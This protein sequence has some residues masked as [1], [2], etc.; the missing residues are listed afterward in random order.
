MF[1]GCYQAEDS[2]SSLPPWTIHPLLKEGALKVPNWEPQERHCWVFLLR[3]RDQVQSSSRGFPTSSPHP[4]RSGPSLPP[5]QC[6][7]KLSRLCSVWGSGVIWGAWGIL[8]LSLLLPTPPKGGTWESPLLEQK[9]QE[10]RNLPCSVYNIDLDGIWLLHESC[11][12]LNSCWL[13][14]CGP[15]SPKGGRWCQIGGS[16]S[17][18]ARAD[19]VPRGSWDISDPHPLVLTSHSLAPHSLWK[20]GRPRTTIFRTHC[21]WGTFKFCL[22]FDFLLKLACT[23]VSPIL[24]HTAELLMTAPP[25]TLTWH[26]FPCLAVIQSLLLGH[27]HP[28]YLTMQ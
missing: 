18:K 7:V 5:L 12:L 28:C 19:L 23:A 20:R 24:E 9:L 17:Y 2:A 1:W 6:P 21:Y 3:L 27:M 11:F 10:I 16:R 22:T 14:S 8:L 13:C 25:S 26:H 15:C 4:I